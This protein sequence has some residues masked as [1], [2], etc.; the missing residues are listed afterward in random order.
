MNECQNCGRNIGSTSLSNLRA[1][2][3]CDEC[4]ET[5]G[6]GESSSREDD[7]FWKYALVIGGITGICVL[8]L[9]TSEYQVG[10]ATV[11]NPHYG[12]AAIMVALGASTLWGVHLW[13]TVGDSDD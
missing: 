8:K 2:P 12:L 6:V 10:L 5:E 1:G 4:W 13:K 9:L 11:S 7:D 3:Y